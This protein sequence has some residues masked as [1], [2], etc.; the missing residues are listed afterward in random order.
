MSKPKP[1]TRADKYNKLIDKLGLDETYTKLQKKPKYDKVKE[2]IPPL[3]DY[4]FQADLLMLPQTKKGFK[5]LLVVVDLWSDEFDA[6]P[7]KSKEPKEVLSAMQTILKRPHLN[8]PYATIRTDAGTEFKG[9]FHKWLFNNDILHSV[10]LPDRH[11]QLGNVESLNKLLD[12]FFINYMNK[13]EEETK[14]IYREWTDILPLLVKEMNKIR[15][16]KDKDPYEHN[17]PISKFEA[18]YKVGD[19][20][21]HKLDA[22]KNALN[23]KEAGRFRVGDYRYDKKEPRKIVNVLYYPRNIRYVLEGIDNVSYT[24]EELLPSIEKESKFSVNKLIGKKSV[25]RTTYYRVWFKNQLKKEAQWIK[26]TQLHED[27]LDYLME[28]F[29]KEHKKN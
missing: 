6:E 28:Q 3:Q 26:K 24:E 9:V 27:G 21:V 25:G 20:V 1:I 16:N 22:P 11:K 13:K 8:K 5:Y 19:I 29:D 12:R 18:K 15:R 4:N 10:A 17:Y 14:K 7:L 2:N 23:K